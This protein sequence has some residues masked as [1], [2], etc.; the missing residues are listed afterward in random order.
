MR[1]MARDHGVDAGED[2]VAIDDVEGF[3]VDV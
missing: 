1:A 3:D 2:R